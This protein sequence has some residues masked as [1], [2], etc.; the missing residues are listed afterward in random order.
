MT[1]SLYENSSDNR[2]VNKELGFQLDVI[3]V[4]LKQPTSI[5]QPSFIFSFGAIAEV[6]E[7]TRFNYL[8]CKE[9]DRYYY[10]TNMSFLQGKMIQFDCKVDVL[11][12]F[13]N[14]IL[15]TTQY[16]ARQEYQR[17]DYI[18]DEEFNFQ[19]NDQLETKPFGSDLIIDTNRFIL[20]TIG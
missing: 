7:Y 8:Y 12:S 11:M 1:I 14:S 17:N 10:I 6:N 2:V 13:K 5:I 3:N 19:G 16:I 4:T 9:F 15:D 20:T 18:A